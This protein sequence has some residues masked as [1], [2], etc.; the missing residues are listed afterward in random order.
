MTQLYLT[1]NEKAENMLILT[2]TALSMP[3]AIGK[4]MKTQR[5]HLSK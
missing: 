5:I 1:C 3:L 4:E 2:V